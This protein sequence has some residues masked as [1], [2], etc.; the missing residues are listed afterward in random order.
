MISP[1]VR[2]V[3]SSGTLIAVRRSASSAQDSDRRNVYRR[4]KSPANVYRCLLQ[5]EKPSHGLLHDP[6]HFSAF[7]TAVIL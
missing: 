5:V 4:L 7:R 2:K 3:T 1:L 6:G